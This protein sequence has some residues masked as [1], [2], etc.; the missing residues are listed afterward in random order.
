MT[1][2]LAAALGALAAAVP[3]GLR[4]LRVIQREHYLPG[5][6]TR[7]ARRWWRSSG[8]NR[9]LAAVSLLAAA[10]AVVLPPLV[11][12]PLLAA[13]LGPEGLGVRG[14]TGPLV[15]TERL[16]RLAAVSALGALGLLGLAAATGAVWLAG[17]VP[18][19]A[20]LLV[21][22]A[23]ALVAP[24][25]RR[26]GER[27]VAA[28]ADRIGASGAR[29]VAVTGSYGKTT[30]KVALAH[31]LG[32][33]T[34][35]FASPASFNNRMGL[36]RA[37]NEGLGDDT[38]VFIAEMGTYGRGEIAELCSWIPPDVAVITA[39][40]PVHLERMGSEAE[41][42][43]A[44]R[45]ILAAA[46]VA[47]LSVDHPLLAAVAGEEEGRRRVVRTSTVERT[48]DVFADP[49]TGELLVGG[50][51]VGAFDPDRIHAGNVASA[52]GAV[53]GLGIDPARVSSR[54]GTLPVPDHRQTVV[55]SERGFLILDD[56]FNSNP[57]GARAALARL[58]R[59]APDGRRVV[60]TPGMVELGAVQE[61]EN[62]RFAAD[63]AL[64]ASTIVVVGRTNRRALVAGASGADVIV[65]P[66]R[67][68][69]VAW[70]RSHLGD[71]DAVLYENDLPDHYP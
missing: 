62:R 23:A 65:V 24:G 2:A 47:V 26:R 59:L 18:L 54:L 61:E 16:R 30:T 21:D 4:W 5:A 69:A 50:E 66:S 53:V 22:G 33:G 70:V 67:E 48:A 52:M 35:V 42:V 49:E 29:V 38:E 37:V 40:G 41:I 63:A 14:R 71:G 10:G 11:A 57:A 32:A 51:S 28:A 58:A 9:A 8:L 44:K 55:R 20:P 6:A 7:F 56:T 17:L 45:E 31:L 25:E 36:A 27:W 39:I 3:A 34:R 46:P 19:A 13:A 64:V 12:V 68:E 43:A 15:W 60:V 1:A